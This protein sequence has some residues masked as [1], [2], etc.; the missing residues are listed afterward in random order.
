MRERPYLLCSL[1]Y[2]ALPTPSLDS[3]PAPSFWWYSLT[4]PQL[5]SWD[6]AR[7]RDPH[8]WLLQTLQW[9]DM[10]P[11]A[12]VIPRDSWTQPDG[13]WHQAATGWGFSCPNASYGC[14]S[15]TITAQLPL[16][17]HNNWETSPQT[18]VSGQEDSEAGKTQRELVHGVGCTETAWRS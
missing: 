16:W 1:P 8:W 10:V 14:A 17:Y 18:A 13:T 15:G 5:V 6:V 9:W 3:T 7:T 2:Q 4:H 11:G 12:K